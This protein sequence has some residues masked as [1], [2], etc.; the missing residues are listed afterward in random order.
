MCNTDIY[1]IYTYTHVHT[2]CLWKDT[3]SLQGNECQEDS[4]KRKTF[5]LNTLLF[6]N[7]VPHKLLSIQKIIKLQ[8]KRTHGVVV[9]CRG[10]ADKKTCG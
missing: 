5:S 7:Y 8:T 3:D 6:L 4:D 10:S 1:L 2:E 9:T